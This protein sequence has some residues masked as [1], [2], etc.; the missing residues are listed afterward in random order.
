M[1]PKNRPDAG[2][3]VEPPKSAKPPVTLRLGELEPAVEER[4]AGAALGSIVRRDLAR[5]Y[6]LLWD[7]D[8]HFGEPDEADV[9]AHALRGFDE[10][11][12]RYIWAA[13]DEQLDERDILQQRLRS[14][15]RFF[16]VDR[17]QMSVT[18]RRLDAGQKIALIDAVERYWS[19]LE[20]LGVE[21][22]SG[23][24][25]LPAGHDT[26]YP[27]TDAELETMV[28]VGLI[29]EGSARHYRRQRDDPN[30]PPPPE[31][32]SEA[33]LYLLDMQA[34]AARRLRKYPGVLKQAQA[35]LRSKRSPKSPRK[36]RS[37]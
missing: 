5:Y 20:A 22:P 34:S 9:V 32:P 29:I 19:K 33:E 35:D 1:T 36:P 25:G 18:L 4:A 26:E 2:E 30:R 23:A 8:I 6:R 13:V 7:S 16:R 17:A 14:N 10:A 3:I 24:I 15:G 37:K 31:P 21:P 27:V 28:H 11:A 12:Y